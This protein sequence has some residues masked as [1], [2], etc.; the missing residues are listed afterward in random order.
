M[1]TGTRKTGEFCWSNMLTPQP[2][3]ARAF[4]GQLLGWRYGEIPGLGHVV[5]VGGRDIGGVFDLAGPNTPP[6]TPPHIGVMVKV[7]SAD[8]VGAKVTSLGGKA[9]PAFDIKD[10][11]RMAACTDPNGARFDVWEPKKFLG[12]NAD[13]TLHGAPSWFET[14][15]IDVDRTAKFYS[16]LFGWTPEVMP[17]PGANYTTFKHGGAD[18]AGMMQ[19]T[20]QM[21]ELRPH[22]TTYFSVKDADATAREAVNLGAKLCMTMKDVPGVSR[23]CGITSPQ[24]VTF[25]VVQYAT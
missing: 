19:I 10:Q 5:K 25:R 20:P 12:T 1:T 16:E 23:F 22:W 15:T 3:Q 2:E 14:M 4:F 6:G 24:G 7:E 21:G 11:G 9:K 13:S 17:M 8:A 18:V